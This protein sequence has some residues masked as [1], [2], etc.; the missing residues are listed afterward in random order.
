VTYALEKLNSTVPGF[1]P[2]KP[3]SAPLLAPPATVPLE[4]EAKT[5][6]S[7]NPTRP[8]TSMLVAAPE[9]VPAA[10]LLST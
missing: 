6:P 3:P 7:F 8:P 1:E 4:L 10:E 5:M 9:T 2:T